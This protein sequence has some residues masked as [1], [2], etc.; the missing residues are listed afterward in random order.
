MHVLYIPTGE[1]QGGGRLSQRVTDCE[2]A[3]DETARNTLV[4]AM[5]VHEDLHFSG[6]VA[7][8]VW[9][10]AEEAGEAEGADEFFGIFEVRAGL[11]ALATIRM[12]RMKV[13]GCG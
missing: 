10:T 7:D 2:H 6:L 9:A 1:G 8:C 12:V 13:G 3:V 11:A 4:A 5:R